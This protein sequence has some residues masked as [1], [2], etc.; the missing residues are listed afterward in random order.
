MSHVT[1]F[2]HELPVGS[3]YD[4]ND[5]GSQCSLKGESA[6]EKA[7]HW[8]GLSNHVANSLWLTALCWTI[9]TKT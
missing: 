7:R 1:R 3:Q 8:V 6:N 9:V 5:D 4:I 2:R